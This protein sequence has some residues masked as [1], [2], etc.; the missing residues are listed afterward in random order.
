MPQKPLAAYRKESI[1]TGKSE[2]TLALE[3][4]LRR[5]DVS[6]DTLREDLD[7]LKSRQENIYPALIHICKIIEGETA[8]AIVQDLTYKAKRYQ[9]IS[10]N[11]ITVAYTT[12][13]TAGA[14]VVTVTGP[15]LSVQIEDSVSTADQVKAA[16]C[17]DAAAIKLINVS[18]SGTGSNA[19][20]SVSAT[21]LS[22][23]LG[24]LNENFRLINGL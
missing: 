17:A 16:I 23:G 9:G 21:N 10:G 19:Q 22:G 20:S 12:G 2:A 24:S 6:L 15:A 1:R 5:K 13:A 8:E 3:E 14:E 4:K 11:E 18:V 7:Y